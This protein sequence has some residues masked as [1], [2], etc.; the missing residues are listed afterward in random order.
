M[1]ETK[2]L[3]VEPNPER[4]PEPK[5][6]AVDT[7]TGMRLYVLSRHD[8]TAGEIHS[9]GATL[10][11]DTDVAD[12]RAVV[13]VAVGADLRRCNREIADHEDVVGAIEDGVVLSVPY[14]VS[15]VAPLEHVEDA[16]EVGG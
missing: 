1:G 11:E 15:L 5:S 8:H 13:W 9:Q 3:T 4:E 16:E 14:P 12:D 7:R 2:R 6:V 10:A